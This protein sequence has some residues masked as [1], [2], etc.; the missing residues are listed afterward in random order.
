MSACSPA[1]PP[2]S[3]FSACHL[4]S[5]HENGSPTC[6]ENYHLRLPEGASPQLLQPKETP[7]SP[8]LFEKKKLKKKK[9]PERHISR[10]VRHSQ[11]AGSSKD[12]EHMLGIGR[13]TVPRTGCMLFQPPWIGPCCACLPTPAYS[14]EP[15]PAAPDEEALSIQLQEA[16]LLG[17]PHPP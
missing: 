14:S 13:G 17:N 9:I 8:K 5:R 1:S 12:M 11:G 3:L 2:L 4:H 7:H 10:S 15:S 6:Q 16:P